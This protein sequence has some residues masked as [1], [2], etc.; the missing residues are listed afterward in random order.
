[1]AHDVQFDVLAKVRAAG[2]T[3]DA[4]LYLSR[5]D[6]KRLVDGFQEINSAI[7]APEHLVAYEGSQD[8]SGILTYELDEDLPAG[9]G[10]IERRGRVRVHM[11]LAD[12]IP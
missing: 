7:Y 5:R 9:I 10:V 2:I 8:D 11:S 4:T 1:M 12:V 3:G 6:A